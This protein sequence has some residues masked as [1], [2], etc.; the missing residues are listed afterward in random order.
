MG[1]DSGSSDIFIKGED[2][3]GKPVKRYHCGK[4]CIDNSDHYTIGYLDGRLK[5]YEKN[6][7]V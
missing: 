4:D 6:L 1:I 2:S 3:K 7:E 5:T